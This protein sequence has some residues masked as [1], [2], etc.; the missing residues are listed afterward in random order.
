MTIYDELVARGLVAQVTSEDEVKNLINNGKATFYI[1]YDCTA[2]SLTAGHFVTLTLMKRLQQAGNKPIALIGGGTTT[3]GD[4]S[5]RT[6]M[7]KMLSRE[8]INHNAQ[9][10]K[11]QMERFIEFG[12]GPGKAMMVNN[13]DW[14]DNLN[15]IDFLRE[16]GV[17]FSVN[18]MLTAECFKKRMEKGLSFLEFN[19]MLMQSY[20]F[21][22]LFQTYGV[23]L[24]C[25]GDD[26][27]SNILA[28]A[29]LIRRKE[30]K[31]AFAMTFQLLTTSEGIKMG[32]TQKGAL[33]LDREK[34]SPYEF[35]QYWRNV[36]DKDVK[37][38]LSLLTFL[39]MKEV[40]RLSALEGSEINKAKEVLAFELTKIVHNEQEALKAQEAAKSL[41][42]KGTAGGSVPTT[43]MATAEFVDGIDIITLLTTAGIVPSRSEAR[44]LVQQGGIK[45]ADKK[46][47]TIEHKVSIADFTNNELLIQK[48]KKGFHNIVIF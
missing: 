44:R 47:D 27:W 31:P 21:L 4:P 14:L 26:Q 29:D 39:P 46:I 23:A 16:V 2:D 13:A 37:K 28:G 40:N 36:G 8:D 19:Y 20:D 35:Y 32:K 43:E 33:W 25:G 11:H 10:F 3:I 15:Y 48:G 45:V 34:T 38:C 17:H 22:H 41:F 6:D 18:R 5:G 9:C 42:G 1:G 12:E 7:R 24:Q 30:Q